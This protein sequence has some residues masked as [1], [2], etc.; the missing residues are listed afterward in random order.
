MAAFLIIVLSILP[1]FVW[2]LFYLK[3][4]PHPEP[5]PLLLVAFFLGIF[6]TVFALG[7][8]VLF[9]RGFELLGLEKQVVQNSFWFM[10]LG[11]A[12]VEE[13]FKFLMAFLFLRRNPAFDEPIDA[14]I[15]LAVIA[16]GFAFV[17]NII[18]LASIFNEYSGSFSQIIYFLTLRFI[19][20]N[21]LHTLASGLVGYFWAIGIVKHRVRRSVF[22]GLGLA[23]LIHG[24]FNLLV[25]VFGMPLYVGAVSL[26][27]I[28]AL[29]L[30]RDAEVLR[31]LSSPTTLVVYSPG[32][33]KSGQESLRQ[34][35]KK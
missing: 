17:E 26:L 13:V 7:T 9:L 33:L 5:P 20:A 2:L 15:Y 11:V 12:L 24:L 25:I 8:G 6:S 4:D 32:Y 14:V 27:F 30:L 31:Q 22:W 16:L 18:Y 29:F 35:T 3:Q 21:F 10:F 1:N 34:E 19:G 28:L 23:T